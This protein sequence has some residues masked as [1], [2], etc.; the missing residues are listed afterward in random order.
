MSITT[1]QGQQQLPEEYERCRDEAARQAQ[2]L[3]RLQKQAAAGKSSVQDWTDESEESTAHMLRL[4]H[5]MT[6]KDKVCH[7]AK[8]EVFSLAGNVGLSVIVELGCITGDDFQIHCTSLG[9]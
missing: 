9:S 1:L 5:M 4:C 3:E 6:H 8:I 7:Y 2:Q